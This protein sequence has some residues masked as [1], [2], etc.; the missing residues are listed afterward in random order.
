MKINSLKFKPNS[1]YIFLI[2]KKDQ[3]LLQDKEYQLNVE[4]GEKNHLDLTIILIRI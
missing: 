2:K 4:L 3:A 1:R